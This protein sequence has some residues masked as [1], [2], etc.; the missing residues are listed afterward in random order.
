MKLSL[1]GEL[2]GI[3]AVV[4]SVGFVAYELR[5]NTEAV[6]V[7]NHQALVAMD[8]EKNAWLRDPE[9]A[10]TYVRARSDFG[11]LSPVQVR[12]YMTFIADT[13][14]AWE[15]AHIT[16]VDGAMTENIWLGWD[17]FYRSELATAG[18]RIFWTDQRPN[19]SPAFRAYVDS[20]VAPP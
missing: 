4:V 1:W 16:Y 5:Q 7:A 2:V 19:Y 3:V 17:G 14:N 18:G 12:Q 20:I 6:R 8:L 9:F 13:F 15:F 11:A 10:E